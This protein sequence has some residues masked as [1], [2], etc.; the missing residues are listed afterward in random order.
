MDFN[1]FIRPE[2]LVLVPVLYLIGMGIKKSAA[3]DKWIPVVLG[4]AGV[5]L[6]SA[7]L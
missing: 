1:E 7:Y 5:V 6:A 4:I 3:K 2:L